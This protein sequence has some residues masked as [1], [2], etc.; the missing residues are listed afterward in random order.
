[1]TTFFVGDIINPN[2]D[3]YHCAG[4]RIPVTATQKRTGALAVLDTL[5]SLYGSSIPKP[6]DQ[7][8][9]VR[10]LAQDVSPSHAADVLAH[11]GRV[12]ELPAMPLTQVI[13][14]VGDGAIRGLPT[15]IA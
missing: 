14:M 13:R 5:T 7:G 8:W 10:P 9:A 1:M 2:G 4:T 3:V 11:A 12:V 6:N 15:I